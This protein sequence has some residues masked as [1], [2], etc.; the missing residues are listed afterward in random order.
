MSNLG[1]FFALFLLGLFLA[2]TSA[3]TVF[4]ASQVETPILL[5][6]EDL[7]DQEGESET[8]FPDAMDDF[9]SDIQTFKLIQS[10]SIF[11]PLVSAIYRFNIYPSEYLEK[12][13][14]PPCN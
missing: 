14:R 13:L 8:D 12:A 9:F 10:S 6:A 3:V 7:E 5:L 2:K 1:R 4:A 11:S